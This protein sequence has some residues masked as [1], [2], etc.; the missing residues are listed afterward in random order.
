MQAQGFPPPG[1]PP[2]AFW[3][4]ICIGGAIGL[5][6]WEVI[7]F[8]FLYTLNRALKEVAGPNRTISLGVVWAWIVVGIVPVV[9]AVWLNYVVNRLAGSIRKEFE[10]RGW[11]TEGE[12]FGRLAGLIYGWG[13]L[14]MWPVNVVQIYLQFTGDVTT[15]TVI[16]LLSMPVSL[17]LL[18]SFIVYWVLMFLYGNRLKEPGRRSGSGGYEDDFDDR[19]A[20]FDRAHRRPPG[21]ADRFDDD[22]PPRRDP[23]D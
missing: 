14:L 3:T 13:G 21:R 19:L 9:G 7:A 16:G 1:M 18:A 11:P 22:R 23:A 10:D 2:E 17:G 12:R 8:F 5:T 20:E 6:I 15:A 4:A